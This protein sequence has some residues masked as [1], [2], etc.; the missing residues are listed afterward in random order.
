MRADRLVALMLLLQTRGKMTAK[1]LARELEVSRRTILRDVDAL[2]IAGVP[3]Y[4]EGGH[5]GGITLDEA[6][7]TT[8]TGLQPQEVRT[9]FIANYPAVLRDVGLAEAGDHLQRKLLASLPVAHQPIVTHIQQRLMID[10]TWWW[11]D[12][13]S[14]AFWNDLQQAVYEDRLIAATYEHYDGTLVERILAPYSLVNKSSHWYLIALRE[15]EFRTYRVVRFHKVRLLPE[16]F[17]RRTDFDL[18]TYWQ[19]QLQ[20]F[21]TTFSEYQCTLRIHPDRVPYTKWLMTGRWK[22]VGNA[23]DAGWE[24]LQFVMDDALMAR[25]LVF[26][27]GTQGEVIDPP[28]LQAEVVATAQA[29]L[30]RLDGFGLQA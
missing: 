13:Q 24:T 26:G 8:L 19:E 14:P 1:T 5:G 29:F 21:V 3:I 16:H 18:P 7:R 17:V 11:H 30:E 9:L 2:S 27:L 28:Q 15:G 20:S 10:P 6:Y 23:D 4:C 12:L 25:M 22:R